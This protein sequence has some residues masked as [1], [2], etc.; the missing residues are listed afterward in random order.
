MTNCCPSSG[1]IY[2]A[3]S[4]AVMSVVPAGALGTITVTG[5]VG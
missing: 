2:S 1:E 3:T 5:R 4:R